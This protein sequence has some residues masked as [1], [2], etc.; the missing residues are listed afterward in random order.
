MPTNSPVLHSEGEYAPEWY[1]LT[2]I[3]GAIILVIRMTKLQIS[4]PLRV[5]DLTNK[6]KIRLEKVSRD[7]ARPISG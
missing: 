2:P 1:R 7:I 4:S 3:P 6:L 5:V